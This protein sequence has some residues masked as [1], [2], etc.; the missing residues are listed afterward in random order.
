VP[1][2]F[3][4]LEFLNHNAVR[5][6]PVTGDS[7]R[8]SSNGSTTFRLPDDF[9][10]AMYLPIHWGLTVEPGKFYLKRVA[11]YA[12]GYSIVVGYDDGADGVDVASALI[13]KSSHIP[14]Q[15]YNL[16]GIGDF[17]DSRGHVVIGSLDN[18]DKQPPGQWEFTLS[19]ARLEPDVV[20]PNIRGFTSLQVQNGSELSAELYGPVRL[21][22]GRD[23]RITAIIEP[24]ED[25]RLVFDAIEGAGLTQDCDCEDDVDPILTINGEGPDGT[26]NFTVLG[27]DCLEPSTITHGIELKDTCSDPCC[28]CTELEAITQAL[29]AFGEKATTLENFLVNLEARV[30]QMDMVVLGS[31]L[32]DRGCS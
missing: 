32:G 8:T 22:A 24:G 18:I 9:I 3:R 31:R 25:T 10:V 12:T 15:V 28:G 6:Y 7:S 27:N 21:I 23:F 13:A 16:G 26:G 20:R 1:I 5:A 2:G 30:T 19:T 29:E 14:N 4:N 17:A 11:V